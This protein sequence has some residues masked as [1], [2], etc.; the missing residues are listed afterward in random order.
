MIKYVKIF[1]ERNSG[2]ETVRHRNIYIILSTS[3]NMRTFRGSL[4]LINKI[5]API[6]I[7]WLKENEIPYDELYFGKPWGNGVSYI[8]DKGLLIDS[9]INNFSNY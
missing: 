4:G 5:T 8:D 6:L 9:F 7:K 3:R 2:T 1:G